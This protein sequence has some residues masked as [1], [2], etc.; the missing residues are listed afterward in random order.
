M[1]DP[2]EPG[3]VCRV[4]P[5]GEVICEKVYG[6]ALFESAVRVAK[7]SGG[8]SKKADAKLK[9]ALP[10]GEWG[11]NKIK[12]A[13][14]LLE[15]LGASDLPDEIVPRRA[16]ESVDSVRQMLM[17]VPPSILLYN[18]STLPANVMGAFYLNKGDVVRMQQIFKTFE[19]PK[20]P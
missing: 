12:L 7:S 16:G 8:L 9:E 1:P 15:V 2:D 18:Y 14:R 20:Q 10:P 3:V 4:L 5:D 11:P 17:A 13:A 19:N 6:S